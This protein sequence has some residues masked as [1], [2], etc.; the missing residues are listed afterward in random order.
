MLSLGATGTCCHCCYQQ[1]KQTKMN[2]KSGSCS[3]TII[4]TGAMRFCII[5][6]CMPL[7]AMRERQ[8]AAATD[9]RVVSELNGCLPSAPRKSQAVWSS[10]GISLFDFPNNAG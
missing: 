2:G 4:D 8:E 7:N 6:L 1:R 9:A 3:H 5:E 10:G